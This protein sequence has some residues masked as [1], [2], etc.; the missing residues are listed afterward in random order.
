[1]ASHPPADWWRELA[2]LQRRAAQGFRRLS[3]IPPDRLELGTA[4]KEAVYQEDKVT[5]YRY[6]P[7]VAEPFPVPLLIVYSLVNRPTLVDLQENRSLARHLLRLGLDVYLIDWGYPTRADRWLTM[8]DYITGY[9]D[10]CLEVVRARH[11]LDA[12]NLLGICQGG[13]FALCYAALFPHKVQNLVVM[14]TPVDFHAGNSVISRWAGG[15]VDVDR[16]VDAL[17]NIPGDIL[18]LGF[19]MRQPFGLNFGKYFGLLD[20]FEDEAR[21]LSFLHVEKWSFDS[22]DQTGEAFRQ[23]VRDCYQENRLVTGDLVLG[24]RRVDLGN[25]RMPVL[26]LH[27][28]YDDLVPV[29][30]VEPL[31]DLVGTD[32]YTVRCFPVGH[33][34]MYVSRKVQDTLP[35]LIAAWV[36]A[37]GA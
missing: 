7:V 33:I 32:D 22:P 23:F 30:S 29:E 2:E 9:V 11:G 19:L 10:R 36:Q 3:A 37:R 1:M 24:E 20:L 14:V 16:A 26:N 28:Q 35:P 25:I 13:V 17:G 6:T 5:L 34:G 18:N 12:I 31:G 27:A 8:D 21:L 15:D 4:P